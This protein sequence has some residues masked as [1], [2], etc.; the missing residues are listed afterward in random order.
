MSNLLLAAAASGILR[1][2]HFVIPNGRTI[3]ERTL[4][5]EPAAANRLLYSQ[6]FAN[7]AWQKSVATLTSNALVAPDGTT[8]G[9]VLV[10]N[11]P[12]SGGQLFQDFTVTGDGV[13]AFSIY[14]K[15]VGADPAVDLYWL[16][17]TTATVRH[18]VRLTFG[19]TPTLTSISGSGSVYGA[20]KAANGWVRVLAN[21][22]G[23]L[24]A[25]TQ[26]L[27]VQ[28]PYTGTDYFPEVGVWGA[29]AENGVVPTSYIPTTSAAVT[30]DEELPYLPFSAKPQP[31][32]A[33]VRFIELG[34]GLDGATRGI[35][36]LGEP[37]TQSLFVLNDSANFYRVYH[38]NVTDVIGGPPATQTAYGDLVELRVT[39]SAAGVAQ[40]HQSINGAAEQ[41]GTA[42]SAL[43]L[44]AAWDSQR[45]Y[46]GSRG[47]N[48]AGV[49][50]F[51]HAAIAKG[52]QDRDT[53]RRLAGVLVP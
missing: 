47:T 15:Q 22:A 4:L 37:N 36:S 28:S 14:L 40:L 32:T 45:F 11:S 7:A 20:Q 46:L 52:S 8:T 13:K 30:R 34:T 39:L 51:T 2:A 10:S 3:P 33:Y 5:I 31:L 49:A 35:F 18:R 48:S 24:A 38:R 29:Q 12:G 41:S 16:D 42:S 27:I 19:T 17:D 21:A 44:A 1:N 25:N 50:G 23:V 43:A 26:T 6:D 53:M 9:D